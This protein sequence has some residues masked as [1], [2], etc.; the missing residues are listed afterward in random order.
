MA[1]HRNYKKTVNISY[2][3]CPDCRNKI[4]IPRPYRTREKNHIK[5]FFCPFCA[6]NKQML[7]HRSIDFNY[8]KSE[9]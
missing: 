3:E 4:P 2:L 5:T 8:D 1:R 7:E 6:E 9:V